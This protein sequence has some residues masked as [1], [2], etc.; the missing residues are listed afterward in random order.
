MGCDMPVSFYK[1]LYDL[2]GDTVRIYIDGG[3][4]A[5]FT[6]CIISVKLDY[7]EVAAVS[8]SGRYTPNTITIIPIHK[9][10]AIASFSKG[11]GS[12]AFN[13]ENNSTDTKEGNNIPCILV[14]IAV[15]LLASLHK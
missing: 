15:I 14:I 13:E 11:N 9:I 4:S 3:K 7:I 12:L 2:I 5:G 8:K 6:G 1:H 10:S